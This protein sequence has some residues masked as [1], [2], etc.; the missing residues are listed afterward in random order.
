MTLTLA[1]RH[2]ELWSA[3]VDMFGPYDLISAF[4]ER[5][6]ETWKTYFYESLGH[7]VKDRDFLIERSPSTYMKDLKAPMLV[8]QGGNDPRVVEAE[9]RLVVKNL[10]EAGKEV[11]IIVFENEGHDVIKYENKVK[12]YNAITD[13]FKEHLKP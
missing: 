2:P 9:S 4:L 11:D 1:M 13:F 5:I 3:A 12:C 10:Q 6:P 8:I 7:P